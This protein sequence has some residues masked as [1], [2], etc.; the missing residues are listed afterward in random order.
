MGFDVTAVSIIF[1]VATL[2]AG[3]AWV[4]AYWKSNETNH[5]ASRDLQQRADD[6]AHTNLTVT[7]ATYDS[8]A[9]RFT[10]EI[11]NTGSTVV[12][13]SDMVYLVDGVLVASAAVE[14][15]SV[16]GHAT[17]DL[18][19]P[20]ETLEARFLPISDQPTHFKAVAA[21]GVAGYWE[22]G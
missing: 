8:G 7:S 15:V 10:V 17:S 11:K 18:L 9:D 19:L 20:A 14:S 1:F 6:V 13:V 22:E 12:D 3:S 2:T 16:V 4:G 5:D 21:N